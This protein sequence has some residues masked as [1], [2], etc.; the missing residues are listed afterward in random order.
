MQDEITALENND[1]WFIVSLPTNKVAIGCKWVFNIKYKASGEV[2]RYKARLVAKGYSQQE[3]LDF[4]ETFPLLQKWLLSGLSFLLLPLVVGIYFR[5][6]FIM[7]FYKVI[8]LKRSTCRFL[9]VLQTRG[10]KTWF[11]SFISPCMD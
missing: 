7:P 6:M 4:T 5:W 1:T 3:S 10:R 2:E 8:F 9:R 11:G